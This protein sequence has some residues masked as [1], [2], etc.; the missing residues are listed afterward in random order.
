[1]PEKKPPIVTILGHVDHG[2]TTLLEFILKK[3]SDFRSSLTAKEA[4][5]ITQKV[6]AFEI[7]FEHNKITFIDTPGH[8]IFTSLRD[9]GAQIADMAILIIAADEGVKPQTKESLDLLEAYK[10]PFIVALNKIDR[11]SA[12]SDKVKQQLA[13]LGVMVEG[14]GGE[15]P[16]VEI[17]A[18]Q[19]QGVADLLE[20]IVLLRELKELQFEPDKPAEGFVLEALKHPRKGSLV[21]LVIQNGTLKINDF[22][23]TASAS[24]KLRFIEDTFGAKPET[25]TA[26]TPV[27]VNGF[28]TLPVAGEI[29]KATSATQLDEVR[30]DLQAREVLFKQKVLIPGGE[31][32][33]D[34]N[35]IIRADH[36][37]TLEAL[38]NIFKKLSEVKKIKLSIIRADLGPITT[39]DIKFAQDA[40]CIILSFGVKNQREILEN[41]RHLRIKFIESDIIY[42]LEE[43]L[44][45]LIE[46]EEKFGQIKGELEVLAMFTKTPTKKTIGGEVKFG[47]LR[48]HNKILITRSA[49]GAIGESLEKVIGHGKI[50][51]LEKNKILTE[52]IEAGNLCGLVIEAS[53][54]I[55]VGDKII[56]Q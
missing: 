43:K 54:D 39:E 17:S 44:G 2:K 32:S 5:G 49:S 24:G 48:R 46:T 52:M 30:K 35:L 6:R 19:G 55:E 53:S 40:N 36:L 37:G 42:E 14:W 3:H 21:T 25:V 38:E 34:F 50:L 8:E 29:F 51:S 56:V 11:P 41:L 23:A 28:E 12:A 22:V 18:L 45:Q 47:F 26:S 1:M 10:I 9:R 13:D 31:S 4:G 27:V 16:C 20:L 15:V 7:T 33:G